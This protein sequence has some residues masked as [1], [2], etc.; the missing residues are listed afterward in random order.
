M[1]DGMLNSLETFDDAGESK[2]LFISTGA[3]HMYKRLA[4]IF[5][6]NVATVETE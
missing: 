2:L 6:L 5:A 3:M 1:K 4:R